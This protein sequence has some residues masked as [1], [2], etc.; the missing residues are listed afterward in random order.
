MAVF[1][2]LVGNRSRWFWRLALLASILA[3]VVGALLWRSLETTEISAIQTRVEGLKP[4][5]TGIR[6]LLIC[7]MVGFWPTIT[8]GL[9]R[10]GHIDEVGKTRLLALR[11]RLL[12]W[13]ILL[14]LTLGQNLL[15]HFVQAIQEG[16][17]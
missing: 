5:F 3:L 2:N 10:R 13:L 17:A 8:N 6:W 14:E 12:A 11:W 9:C 15:S 4:A 16:S 7:L 1:N